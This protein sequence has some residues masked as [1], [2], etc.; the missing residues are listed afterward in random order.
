M[1]KWAW[2]LPAAVLMALPTGLGHAQTAPTPI[3]LDPSYTPAERAADLVGRMT[4]AEKASQANSNMAAAIPR[5]GISAYGWWNEA[6]HGVSCE[7]LTNNSNCTALTNTTSYP[8]SLSAAATW[9][10]PLL[11]KEASLISDEA[12]EVETNN[13]LNMDFYAPVVNLM[14]DPR[15]GRTDETFSEDPYLMTKMAS[16]FV[17]GLQGQDVN[18]TPLAQGGGYQKAIATLKHYAAN[19]SE[20]NRLNGSADMDDRTLREYYTKQ[21][22]DIVG[23]AHPGSLMSSYNSING[24]PSPAN[25]YLTDTLARE[26]FGFGGYFTSDCDAIYEI[27]AGHHWQP[28]GWAAPLDNIARHAFAMSAGEDLDCNTGYHDSSNYAT[29]LPTAVAN[30]IPTQT[31]TFNVNDVDTSLVR[32]FT[33]RMKLGEFDSGGDANP[34]VKAARQR[35][36]QGSWQNNDT[37][38]AVTETPDRLAM[39]RKV[40]DESIVLLKNAHRVLP[41]K[42]PANG[43]FSVAVM[44]YFANPA[45]MYLGDYSSSQGPH[46]MLNEVNG[47]QGLKQAIQAINP[48]A[49]VDY[50][51]GVTGGTSASQLNTVDPASV[52]AASAYNAVVVYVGT[53]ASTGQEAQDRKD[54]ALPGAQGSLISQVAAKNPNTIVYMETDGP[55]DVTGFEPSAP[56]MLW[57]SFNGMRKGESLADVVLG[58]VNPGGHLPFTWYRSAA[59]LPSMTDYAIRPGTNRPG[60]TYMYFGGPASYPFGFGRSYTRF[61]WSNLRIDNTT[62]DANGTIHVSADVSNTGFSAG[63]DVAQLYAST[64]DAPA[65][66][67]RPLRRLV[68]FEKVALDPGQTKTVT[69][70]LRIP[71]LAFFDQSAGAWR[72]DRGRYDLA[73][74]DSS[75]PADQPLLGS[76]TTRGELHP[77]PSVLTVKPTMSG[78]AANGIVQRVAFPAGATVLPNPTIAMSD[79]TLYG[80]VTKGQSRKLP[81]GMKFSFASNRPGVVAVKDG[82]IRTVGTGVATVTASVTYKNVTRSTSFVVDVQ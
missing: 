58:K 78:D 81:D 18:G 22:R 75:A 71:D 20:V 62:P 73:V 1:K 76:I 27:Q 57:S 6:A 70:T 80:Y 79:D 53:D 39:A 34:W 69:F 11:N 38:N 64:P 63:S 60:R 28:P 51:P 16:Q 77:T 56:A 24:V 52:N 40:G 67:E 35:V 15:W 44:G 33:A 4:L 3:Y 43:P 21:F 65:S 47:Y 8:V 41:L 50:Y 74:G 10:P 25:V 13:T 5:L 66:A 55:V 31:D 9:D 42:V 7:T 37:N 46:G 23:A 14:R 49:Q 68:G 2:A 45:S 54:L 30:K 32:L 17:N 82:V 48:L 72:V 36:P 12:R 29:A 59:D 19:N 26:T 61:G